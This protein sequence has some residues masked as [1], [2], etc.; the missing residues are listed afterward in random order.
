MA[1]RFVEQ[2]SHEDYDHPLSPAAASQAGDSHNAAVN[3]LEHRLTCAVSMAVTDLLVADAQPGPLAAEL[4]LRVA[5]SRPAG[6]KL[7]GFVLAVVAIVLVVAH[8][9]LPD[10]VAAVASELGRTAMSRGI[11]KEKNV[12][13]PQHCMKYPK[14]P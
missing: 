14:Q 4:G 8:P 11:W 13:E 6:A 1:H 2:V 9:R 3:T 12:L 5:R 10:A 7:F